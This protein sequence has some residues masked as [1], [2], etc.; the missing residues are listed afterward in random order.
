MVRIKLRKSKEEKEI[1]RKIRAKKAKA[2]LQNY[3]SNLERLQKR[4]FEIGMEAAKLGDEKLVKRQAVKFLA[5]ENRIN[6]ARK[7][8]LLMEEA[9]AQ[10]ELIKVSSSFLTFSKDI[11]DSIAEGPGVDKIAKMHVEFEKA[12]MRVE[13]IEEALSVVVDAASESILTSGEFDDEKVSEVVR[14]LESEA[15]VEEKELDAKIEERLR[16]VED[17]MRKG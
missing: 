14:M 11:V 17:M 16:E 9:E 5:L 2:M 13:S 1:E 15:G 4:I 3:I 12:M 10:K 7:L 6:Q 8:L